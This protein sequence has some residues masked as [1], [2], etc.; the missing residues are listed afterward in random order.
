MNSTLYYVTQAG[1]IL[2]TL[3]FFSLVI[4]QLKKALHKSKIDTQRQKRIVIKVIAA[5]LIWMVV[6]SSLSLSG[7]FSNFDSIP[8][9]F[10]IIV[11]IPLLTLTWTLLFSKTTKEILVHVPKQAIINLQV[12][13]VVVE[14]L[15]W[16][17]FIQ[18]LLPVQM[19]FEGRNFDILAG[20]SAPAVAYFGIVKNQWPRSLL[21]VWNFIS[22]GLLINIVTIAILSFPTP[23]RYFMNEPANTI[24]ANFPF[25]WLPGFLVPL[26]YGLHFLSLR[27]LISLKN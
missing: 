12:F 19:T 21:I 16:L 14:V 6:L 11:I 3:I 20:L 10:I 8:P 25:V 2:T 27:Q 15:L 7:F 5:L 26:A 23:F 9:R 1:F 24:V 22:L 4:E 18:N 13:R 17:L